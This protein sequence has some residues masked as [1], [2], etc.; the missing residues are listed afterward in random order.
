MCFVEKCSDP[1]AK[2]NAHVNGDKFYNGKEV[3]FFC[4]KDYILV[5]S[6]SKKLTCLDRDWRGTIPSCKGTI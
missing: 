6:S 5:P 2:T 1:S 3:E 4:L